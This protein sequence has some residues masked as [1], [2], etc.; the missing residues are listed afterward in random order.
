MPGS[1]GV[2]REELSEVRDV[3]DEEGKLIG[4]EPF[5]EASTAH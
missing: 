1:F 5:Q 3:E 2:G 4:V